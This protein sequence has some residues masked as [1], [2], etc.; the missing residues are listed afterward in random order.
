MRYRPSSPQCFSYCSR[1]KTPRAQSAVG[2]ATICKD[3]VEME[4][5]EKQKRFEHHEEV[6]VD[7]KG[8]EEQ[9]DVSSISS[10]WEP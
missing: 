2:A 6:E 7:V 4:E 3:V 5:K 1:K 10:H 8:G 9:P